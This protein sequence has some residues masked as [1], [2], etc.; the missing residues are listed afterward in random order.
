MFS[1]EQGWRSGESTRF[2]P[3]CP[4]FD[5]QTRCHMWVD[6]V[7]GCLPCSERFFS[8]YSGFP[9]S[10]ETNISKFQFDLD[11]CQALYHEPLARVMARAHPVFDFKFAFTF[12]NSEYTSVYFAVQVTSVSMKS[13][14][15]NC[16]VRVGRVASVVFID[17]FQNDIFCTC[18]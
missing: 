2:P 5:S 3:M 6:F 8:G 9:L 7:V 1:G 14:V 16:L 17:I 15:F 10:S 4:G 13:F 12:S 11:Y 18:T